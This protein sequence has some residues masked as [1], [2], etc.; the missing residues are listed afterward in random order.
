MASPDASHQ[1]PLHAVTVPTPFG[2][3]S[4]FVTPE[5]GVVRA[6]GFGSLV[7]IAQGLPRALVERGWEERDLPAVSSAIRDWIAGDGDA[8]ARVPV[9]QNGG[10]FMQ[11]VWA[12]MRTIPSGETMTYGEL[13][14]L[15][16]NGKAAR[17][18]GH[19]CAINAIAPF[20][21]CHR[22]VLA[23]GIGNYGFGGTD[24]KERMQALERVSPGS[25]YSAPP[26]KRR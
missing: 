6:S 21:P 15:A 2:S 23:S 25:V 11:K 18:A 12:A 24:V 4:A 9:A 20:V 14:A 3:L 8:L 26:V 1:S 16:G 7:R 22:V 13:A 19:A 10:A 17:A 5:D